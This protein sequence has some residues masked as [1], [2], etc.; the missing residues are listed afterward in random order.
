[1]KRARFLLTRDYP[2][3]GNGVDHHYHTPLSKY[4][5]GDGYGNGAGD[6]GSPVARTGFG[7]G[8]NIIDSGDELYGDGQGNGGFW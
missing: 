2:N 8:N 1:M 3:T 4:G 7:D 5:D 6:G